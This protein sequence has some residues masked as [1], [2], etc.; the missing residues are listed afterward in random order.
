MPTI[1]SRLTSTGTLFI[2]GE[3]D[4]VNVSGQQEFTTPGTYSWTAPAGVTSVSAVAI[5]GGANAATNGGGGG[6]LGYR[7]NISVVPGNSYT[8]VVGASGGNSSFDITAAIGFGGSG[9]TGGGFSGE[10]GGIGGAGGGSGGGGGGAGGYTGAG[11]AGSNSNS[12]AGSS[13]TGGGGGGGSRAAG[14]GAYA[15]QNASGGGGG[16]SIFGAGSNGAGGSL[17]TGSGGSGG[18]GGSNGSAAFGIDGSNFQGGAGGGYGGGGGAA[19]FGV[20]YGGAGASGAVR[21]IWGPGRSFPSTNTVND[22]AKIKVT[23]TNIFAREFDEVSIYGGGVT[24]RE[25]NTGTLLVSNGFDEVTGISPTITYVADTSSGGSTAIVV[26]ASTLSTDIAFLFRRWFTDIPPVPSGWTRLSNILEDPASGIADY[27]SVDYRF[28]GASQSIP[29]AAGSTF[30]NQWI[31]VVR[32]SA[33]PSLIEIPF[34]AYGQY[35]D[36]VDPTAL[37]IPAAG[38]GSTVLVVGYQRNTSVGQGFDQTES[39]QFQYETLVLPSDSGATA[40][41]SLYNN[42]TAVNHTIDVSDRAATYNSLGGVVIAIL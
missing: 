23:P 13:S 15:G 36:P 9:S 11:G 29:G 21:V 42:N 33:T 22:N 18:S 24:K 3:F 1:A 14:T 25:T 30:N 4:E 5:G 40:G 26:P 10:G 6:G 37:V 32:P 35:P 38:A 34:V 2:N 28:G 39:P 7:N 41:W 8:V 12:V 16:S 27:F 19:T 17:G 31:V 20:T